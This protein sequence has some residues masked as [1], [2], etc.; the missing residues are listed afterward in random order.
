[1]SPFLEH[2]LQ[3]GVMCGKL[4]L[5]GVCLLLFSIMMSSNKQ[6]YALS[7]LHFTMWLLS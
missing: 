3:K 6:Y 2:T 7:E 1:M 4:A 5:G